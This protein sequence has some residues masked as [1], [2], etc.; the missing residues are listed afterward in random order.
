MKYHVPT[1]HD[2]KHLKR[3]KHLKHLKH[4]GWWGEMGSPLRGASRIPKG[5]LRVN[6]HAPLTTKKMFFI[7]DY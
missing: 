2:A 3:L 4:L 1:M 7:K 5:A 6:N